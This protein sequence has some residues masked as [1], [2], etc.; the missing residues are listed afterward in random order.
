MDRS[1]GTPLGFALVLLFAAAFGWVWFGAP[2]HGHVGTG[3][4][5]AAYTSLTPAELQERAAQP[6]LVWPQDLPGPLADYAGRRVVA[7]GLRVTGVDAAEGFWVEKDGRRAWIQLA[8]PVPGVRPS[9]SPYRVE[10]GDV[11]SVSGQVLPHDPNYPSRIYF[12]TEVS[13]SFQKSYDEVAAAGAHLS[14]SVN[15]LTFGTG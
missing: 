5:L 9:E 2:G 6:P 11:V 12:C 13:P 1:T 4:E 8:E 15:N 3:S 7:N 14:V 10:V